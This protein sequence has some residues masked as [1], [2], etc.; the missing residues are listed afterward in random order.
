M[1]PTVTEQ[2]WK[3]F[4]EAGMLWFVNRILHAFGWSI[5][6]DSVVESDAITR[7]YPARVT[8]RGFSDE[9]EAGGYGKVARYLVQNA[10]ELEREM[11]DVPSSIAGTLRSPREQFVIGDSPPYWREVAAVLP[12]TDL[13]VLGWR[14]GE[15]MILTS[16][17]PGLGTNM[18]PSWLVTDIRGTAYVPTH[19]CEIPALPVPS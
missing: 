17:R 19:W 12:E 5:V 15:P 6:I 3:A 1:K 9:V 14:E 18:G 4:Q 10:V 2:P 16:C 8:W 11:G 13:V 7:V